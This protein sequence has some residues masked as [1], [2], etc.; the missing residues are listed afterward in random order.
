MGLKECVTPRSGP[1][2][3]VILMSREVTSKKNCIQLFVQC[4]GIG[5]LIAL[6][7]D[8]TRVVKMS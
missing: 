3:A 6:R 2:N 1:L 8:P 4:T 5:A 7:N